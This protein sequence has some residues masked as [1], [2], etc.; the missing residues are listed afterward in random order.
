MII[1]VHAPPPTPEPDVRPTTIKWGTTGDKWARGHYGGEKNED[2]ICDADWIWPE[3]KSQIKVTVWTKGRVKI[4]TAFLCLEV[5]SRHQFALT[6]LRGQLR[7][8]AEQQEGRVFKSFIVEMIEDMVD[9]TSRRR[10]VHRYSY[11]CLEV[12]TK[13]FVQQ[14]YTYQEHFMMEGVIEIDDDTRLHKRLL[15]Q[16]GPEA[17]AK[18]IEVFIKGHRKPVVYN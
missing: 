16:K 5:P 18:L 2:Y 13:Y 17:R 6:D 10:N 12:Q 14:T 7:T 9:Y 4:D 15:E 3:D 1:Y 8:A 11:N